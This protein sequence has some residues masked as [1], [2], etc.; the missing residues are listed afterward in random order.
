RGDPA[1][2]LLEVLDPEQN[3]TFQDHY[4]DLPF[5]LSQVLLLAPANTR[6]RLPGPLFDR[7]EVIEVPGY[8][9]TDKL[10]IA[11]EFL[12]PKQLSSHGLTDE[13]LEFTQDGIA[14]IVDHYTSE[15][16]VRGLEREIAAVC[17]ATAVKIAEGAFVQETVTPEHVEQV[18]GPH[19]HRPEHAE[20]DLAPGVA[21]GLA[22]TPGGG[23]IL[24]IEATRM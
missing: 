24:F 23:T 3:G 6:A 12:V 8:T 14:T 13:R 15:A 18:L 17:R 7:M 5:D 22:W 21:T 16:G 19:K 4:L 1:S 20:R 11:R 2:A 10:G 9:R